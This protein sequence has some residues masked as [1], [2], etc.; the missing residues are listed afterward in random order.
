M[1]IRN[2]KQKKILNI[3]TLFRLVVVC[4]AFYFLTKFVTS[5]SERFTQTAPSENMYTLGATLTFSGKIHIDNN[6]PHYT[7]SLV[8]KEGKTIGLKSSTI[9]LNAYTDKKIEVV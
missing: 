1:V 2:L 9:N 8:N 6:F 5:L 3:K 7:H 4:L